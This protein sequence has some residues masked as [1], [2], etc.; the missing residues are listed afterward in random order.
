MSGDGRVVR[1]AHGSGGRPTQELIREVFLEHFTS[2]AL[3]AQGDSAVVDWGVGRLAFTTDAF[4]VSPLFFPGGDI[5]RL[6]VCGSVNDLAVAGATPRALSAAFILEE[7]LPI[8]ELARIAASMGK[9]AREAGVSVVAAD[10]KVVERG[11]GDGIFITTS[12][13]GR[14]HEK[15]PPSPPV[16]SAGDVV[17]V[18]G[19]IGDHGAVIAAFRSGITPAGG[20]ASDCA[21]V[22]PLCHALLEANVGVRFMRD[23]TRGGLATVLAELA[24]QTSVTVRV[25][26]ADIPVREGVR[27]VTELLGLDPLYLACEGRV[28]AVV[29]RDRAAAAL[30]ALTRT[31][32]GEQ[33]RIIG[34]VAARSAQSP[35][36]LETTYGGHRR[37]DLMSGEQ[38]PRIC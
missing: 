32:G 20:L 28:V 12:G 5:G 35:V 16:V 25:R 31:P 6:A 34:E 1:V 29:A 30:E 33:A 13:V 38:L 15:A 18:S 22:T 19:P 4:V 7:G 26:E 8:D 37:Y 36:V 11:H 9:T 2:D 24:Q 23:P 21:P 10:T 17:L 3:A 14:L 27:A